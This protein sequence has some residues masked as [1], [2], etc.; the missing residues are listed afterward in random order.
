MFCSVG[1]AEFRDAFCVVIGDEAQLEY[2]AL[3]TVDTLRFDADLMRRDLGL[4]ATW[5]LDR[6]VGQP[7]SVFYNGVFRAALWAATT[8]PTTP[9]TQLEIGGVSAPLQ[10]VTVD[11]ANVVS[12]DS[13]DVRLRDER[14]DDQASLSLASVLPDN[15]GLVRRLAMTLAQPADPA[16]YREFARAVSVAA[17]ELSDDVIAAAAIEAD[18]PGA[19]IDWAGGSLTA[20]GVTAALIG[21]DSSLLH[22]HELTVNEVAIAGVWA[23][24]SGMPTAGPAATFFWNDL[25][26]IALDA[27]LRRKS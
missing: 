20:T 9:P 14:H 23:D 4:I 22:E 18:N 25:R 6:L 10:V 11:C 26:W 13:A 1:R 3:H 21:V 2:Q 16:L 27:N 7:D 5:A 8:P 15:P 17:A 24:D 19:F 12:G